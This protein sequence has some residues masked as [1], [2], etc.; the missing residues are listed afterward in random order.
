MCVSGRDTDGTCRKAACGNLTAL[1]CF[2]F[3]G[4]GGDWPTGQG[5]CIFLGRGGKLDGMKPRQ[6]E[7]KKQKKKNTQGDGRV[8]KGKGR[9]RQ[10][11]L[12]LCLHHVPAFSCLVF[13]AAPRRSYR[14]R[15]E[16]EGMAGSGGTSQ[17]RM[18]GKRGKIVWGERDRQWLLGGLSGPRSFFK[19]AHSTHS[20]WGRA[21]RDLEKWA[22]TQSIF[23]VFWFFF[24]LVFFFF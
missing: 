1:A 17:Q 19:V 6:R 16:W 3:Y 10:V 12:S 22:D 21:R 15:L 11:P 4:G 5:V 9:D 20:F 23:L 2:R 7:P 14:V 24:F 13:W 8:G 18:D